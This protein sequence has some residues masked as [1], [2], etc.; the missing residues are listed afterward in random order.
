MARVG[1]RRPRVAPVRGRR[2]GQLPAA[3]PGRAH[4][5][6]DHDPRRR[7]RDLRGRGRRQRLPAAHLLGRRPDPG[8]R[9]ERRRGDPRDQRDRSARQVPDLGPCRPRHGRDATSAGVRPGGRHHGSRP[10][11]G[12]ADQHAAR[13]GA[14]EA[15][16]GR[17]LGTAL[18]QGR[19]GRGIYPHPGW[20]ARPGHEPHAGRRPGRVPVRPRGHRQPVLMRPGRFRP[21]P[22]HRPR[23]LLRPQPQHRRHP[24]R[25]SRGRRGL[26][27]G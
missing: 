5:G 7:Q 3:V 14:L 1:R 11:H 15:L 22:A 27:P 16:P 21:A 9:L 24:Y 4:G 13:A 2:L 18:G 17:H 19:R 6:L 12:A 10:D 25:L 8:H 20:P 23:R 26:G